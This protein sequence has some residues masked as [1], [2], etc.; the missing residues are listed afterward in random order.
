MSQRSA[1]RWTDP[2]VDLSNLQARILAKVASADLTRVGVPL[3]A[4]I[5]SAVQASLTRSASELV[6]SRSHVAAILRRFPAAI[7]RWRWDGTNIQ[8]PIQWE[9]TSER[10]VQDILWLVLR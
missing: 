1:I 10:E 2:R 5:W 8:N 7:R 6:L 9:I 4:V 3:A